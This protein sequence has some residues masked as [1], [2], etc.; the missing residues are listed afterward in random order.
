MSR[1]GLGRMAR[2]IA[3]VSILSP[4]VPDVMMQS[5]VQRSVPAM[6][7]GF[8]KHIKALGV[9]SF[10]SKS[11]LSSLN[12]VPLPRRNM[13]ASKICRPQAA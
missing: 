13:S 4:T 11:F 6:N 12:S 2:P 10:R 3:C 1:F 5:V 9:E 7:S 8:E